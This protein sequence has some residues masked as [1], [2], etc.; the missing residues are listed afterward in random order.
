MP[1]IIIQIDEQQ[2]AKIRDLIDSRQHFCIEGARVVDSDGKTVFLKKI[3]LV[4]MP[5]NFENLGIEHELRK[6]P[7][8]D[9]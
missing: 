4:F 9:A 5:D 6:L 7:M 1:Q 8:V 2:E 3:E